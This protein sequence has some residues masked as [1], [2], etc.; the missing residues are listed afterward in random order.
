MI[1]DQTDVLDVNRGTQSPEKGGGHDLR[2]FVVTVEH[3]ES[4]TG[5]DLSAF[6]S[7]DTAGDAMPTPGERTRLVTRFTEI[8]L[9][10]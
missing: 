10:T 9:G 6:R 3:L 8:P 1:G 2:H 4:V 7:I 5:L